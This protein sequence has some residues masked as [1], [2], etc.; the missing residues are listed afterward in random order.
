VGTALEALVVNKESQT[1]KLIDRWFHEFQDFGQS[2]FEALED[3]GLSVLSRS[4]KELDCVLA[5]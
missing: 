4:E 2:R 3:A 5:S 1:G